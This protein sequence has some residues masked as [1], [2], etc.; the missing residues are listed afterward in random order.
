MWSCDAGD[1]LSKIDP[2]T[3]RGS[4]VVHVPDEVCSEVAFGD[5]SLW[6]SLYDHSLI[7]R[8]DPN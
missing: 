5:G 3:N 6:L 2:R 8:I 7:Y 1:T 4:G